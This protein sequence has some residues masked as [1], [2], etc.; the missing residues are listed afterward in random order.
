MQW[1]WLE[2]AAPGDPSENMAI[3]Q[4]LFDGVVRGEAALPLV[5][6]YRWDR[7]AVSV[8]RLQDLARV[9]RAFPGLPTVRRPTG[10]RAVV[11]GQDVTVSVVTRQDW[12]P[13]TSDSGVLSSYRRIAA[14]LTEAFGAVGIAAK[15]GDAERLG[16]Q[17]NVVDCFEVS[18]GCDLVER[19]TGRKLVGSAQ[20]RE[21]GT[22]LQQMSIPTAPLPDERLFLVG[23]KAGLGRALGVS[24]WVPVDFTPP[25]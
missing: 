9:E 22:L 12:L 21:G 23:L 4:A 25:V 20:R 1:R 17:H 16:N 7:R 10:G 11:H 5:R 2:D 14:G 3:D 15:M 19:D 6:V 24:E 8:G 18:A 13:L